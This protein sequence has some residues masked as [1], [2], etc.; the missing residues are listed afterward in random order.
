[1]LKFKNLKFKSTLD[2][3]ITRI[4]AFFRKFKLDKTNINLKEDLKDFSIRNKM[5]FGFGVI[6]SILAISSVISVTTFKYFSSS[7]SDF[8]NYAIPTT[9]VSLEASKDLV[10]AREYIQKTV[11][12]KSKEEIT[13]NLEEAKKYIDNLPR[14]IEILEKDYR[15][16]KR[17]LDLIKYNVSLLSSTRDSLFNIMSR[18]I[19]SDNIPVLR[20]QYEKNSN[21]AEERFSDISK[22]IVL[23]SE[24]YLKIQNTHELKATVVIAIM[25]LMNIVISF[26]ICSLLSKLIV[27]PIIKIKNAFE[28]FSNGNLD[29]YLDYSSNDELGQLCNS[30]IETSYTLKRYIKEISYVLEEMANGNLSV[31]TEIEFKGDFENIGNSLEKILKSLNG[32]MNQIYISAEEVSSGARDLS[33]GAENLSK[34]AL[35]QASASEQLNSKIIDIYSQNKN[36][37]EQA[38]QVLSSASKASSSIKT[39]NIH[40]EDMIFAMNDIREKSNSISKIIKTIDDIAFQTNILALNAAV[41]AAR[42]GHA[43]K[44]FAVVANEVR[45]LAQRSSNEAKNTFELIS[46]TVKAVENG[47]EKAK[48]TKNSMDEVVSRS[49]D[50]SNKANLIYET[51]IKQLEAV[52][53]ITQSVN[54]ITDVVHS[55]SIASEQS[56]T[57]SRELSSQAENLKEL[58][59]TFKLNEV[60]MTV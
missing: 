16:D 21:S 35:D 51:S 47:F 24:E 44:G 37:A 25:A 4:K 59:K 19:N 58:V 15:G 14:T 29:V 22:E 40:M 2:T 18:D 5:F 54:Q 31:D 45:N 6:I 30:F 48:H 32:A 12:S 52:E 10:T 13:K 8:T 50:I 33:E 38:E 23:Y 28:E 53:E 9:N 34:G 49:S 46:Q 41:E 11:N 17:N 43:G 7:I 27:K 36:S 1:M 3:N 39:S 56:S 42:A 57:S 55:N 20:E 60:Y 26:I